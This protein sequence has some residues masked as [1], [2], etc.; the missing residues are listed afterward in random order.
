MSGIGPDYRALLGQVLTEGQLTAPRGKPCL[1][2]RGVV[3]VSDAHTRIGGAGVDYRLATA[4]AMAY[5]AGWDDVE[6]LERFRP[7]YGQFSDDGETLHGA[8]GRRLRTNLDIAV[9]R[10]RADP[11]SRQA[12]VNIWDSVIDSQP[13]KDLPCNTLVHLLLR[14]GALHLFVHVRSQDAVWGLPYDHDA[15]WLV[16]KALAPCVGATPGSLTQYIDSLHVYTRDAGFYDA[17][18]VLRCLTRSEPRPAGLDLTN[19]NLTTLKDVRGHMQLLRACVENNAEGVAGQWIALVRWLR[20][21][22]E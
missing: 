2:I 16:L 17:E 6:W 3:L 14:E 5:L 15:W 9:E 21:E 10:L 11:D 1:E 7:G 13:S 18:K 20:K 8:Y 22:A 19:S 12:V 4:E